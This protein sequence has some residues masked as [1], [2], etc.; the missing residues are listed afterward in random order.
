MQCLY[1]IL[2]NLHSRFFSLPVE[3]RFDLVV[4]VGGP[5][6]TIEPSGFL[7][8]IGLLQS[9]QRLASL[10]SSSGTSVMHYIARLL[11]FI[12]FRGFLE[13]ELQGW[14]DLGLNV[15]KNGADP[16]CLAPRWAHYGTRDINIEEGW[17]S[18]PVMDAL[19][20]QY[21]GIPRDSTYSRALMLKTIQIWA[22]MLQRAGLDLRDHGDKESQ[23]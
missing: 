22:G 23:A 17:Q 1:L 14:L 19:D 13:D 6:I 16:S 11:R 2:E 7:K 10:R 3:D 20:I 5:G 21:W 4:R 12:A 18:T 8:C 15:L 9:D